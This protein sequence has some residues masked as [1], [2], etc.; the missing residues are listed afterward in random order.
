M[1]LFFILMLFLLVNCTKSE[2][3][4]RNEDDKK[5]TVNDKKSDTIQTL[6]EISDTLNLGKDSANVQTDNE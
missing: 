3:Q 6:P 1:K 2:T 5:S 4:Y